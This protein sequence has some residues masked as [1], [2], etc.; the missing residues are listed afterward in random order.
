MNN[1]LIRPA[2]LADA[3]HVYDHIWERGARE[4]EGYGITREA[5]HAKWEFLTLLPNTACAFVRE[6]RVV[7]VLGA[8]DRDGGVAHTWFQAT[9]EFD[10]VGRGL[11]RQMRRAATD[12]AKRS[13][14][15]RAVL[16]SLCV[17][18][19]APRWYEFIGFTEDKEFRGQRFGGH[20]ERSFVRE[21]R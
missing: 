3:M 18:E 2:T 9:D 8:A 15:K 1:W 11:T 19:D 7:A 13:G 14:L 20:L 5:W 17:S 16:N 4:L 10:R 21:W 12:L 6:G